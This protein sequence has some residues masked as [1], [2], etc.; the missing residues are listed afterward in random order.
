M[1]RPLRLEFPGALWHVTSR[2]NEQREIFRDDCDRRFFV[3]LLGEVVLYARWILHA[4]VLMSNHYHLMIET[5]IL[6]L[7]KGMKK[8]NETY[9]QWFNHRHGRVGHLFQGR[10][11][12]IL[13]ERESHLLELIRYVVLNPVR[14]GAV[15]SARD[16]AWSNYRATAGLQDAESWLEVDWTLRQFH[17][18]DRPSAQTEYQ[19]FV[20]ARQGL[21]Y[22]PWELLRGQIYLGT[23]EFCDRMQKLASNTTCKEYP[24]RQRL[25]VYPSLETMIQMVCSEFGTTEKQIQAKGNAAARKAVAQLG[26]LECGLKLQTIAER[27]GIS[28]WAAAKLARA[29]ETL[30]KSDHQYR[31]VMERIRCGIR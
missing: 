27:L 25:F 17:P 22:K 6:T 21:A 5:P 10:F 24:R 13:V 4:W 29:G 2:G 1:S 7:S 19:R 8:L 18:T 30:E 11:K 28:D 9:A 3:N 14:C 26:R 20:A 15:R 16:Y 12:G 23:D 31:D